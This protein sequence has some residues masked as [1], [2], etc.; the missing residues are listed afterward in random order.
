MNFRTEILTTKTALEIDYHSK[1]MLMG[2]CFSENIGLKLSQN[3]FDVDVNSFGILYNPL[4]IAQALSLLIE[5]RTF[6]E[7]DV[8]EHRGVFHSFYHHGD[9]SSME[10]DVC[11]KQINEAREKASAFLAQTDVLLITFGTA[12]VFSLKETGMV[13]SNCHKL[14]DSFFDRK[15]LTVDEIVDE[16]G[17]LIEKL[18]VLNPQLKILFTV[19]PVRHWK[20]GAHGNQLSKA[21]LLL[22]IDKLQRKYDDLFYFPAYELLMDDLRDYRFYANDMLHPSDFAVSYIWKKFEENYFS[23]DTKQIMG[24]WYALYLA[25]N[26]KAFNE[27]SE[28]HQMFLKKTLDKIDQFEKKHPFIRCFRIREEIK[29]RLI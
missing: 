25:A 10:P 22:A 7:V 24:E 18:R 2:S 28:E 5:E 29:N 4:S 19:S 1:L 13:V 12:Y 9:Y 3:N 21:I 20:D 17:S 23:D 26:H 16:W 14:P 6:T 11:L 8:F 27:C 15:R